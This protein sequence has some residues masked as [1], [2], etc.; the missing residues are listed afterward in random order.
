MG[1]FSA[2]MW[3]AMQLSILAARLV[4]K[5]SPQHVDM[6][7]DLQTQECSWLSYCL[8]CLLRTSA[9]TMCK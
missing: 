3:P 8:L 7:S 1:M 9:D 2:M 5:I 4:E 6:V